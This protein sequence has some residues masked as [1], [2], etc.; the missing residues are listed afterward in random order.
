MRT[1]MRPAFIYAR[2][3]IIFL[4][5]AYVIFG[6]LRL[7]TIPMR[8]M[9]NL[10]EEHLQIDS[11]NPALLKLTLTPDDFP[12]EY[13]WYYRSLTGYDEEAT[14]RLGGYYSGYRFDI[15]QSISKYNQNLFW[16][17]DGDTPI[18]NGPVALNSVHDLSGIGVVDFQK[19]ECQFDLDDKVTCQ[20][21]IGASNT[22]MV[23]E[24]N[25]YEQDNINGMKSILNFIID[26]IAEKL[27]SL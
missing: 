25:Y 23:L 20:L 13:R 6:F 3:V 27:Q 16:A 15:F 22:G 17:K 1:S 7:F 11:A 21:N 2:N 26:E 18:F 8:A 24:I 12:A 9:L 4:I 19:T 5:S 10:P 14:S